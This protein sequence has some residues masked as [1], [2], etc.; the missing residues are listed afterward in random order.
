MRHEFVDKGLGFGFGALVLL[1]ALATPGVAMAAGAPAA[2]PPQPLA[3]GGHGS[4]VA[5]QLIP[6]SGGVVTGTSFAADNAGLLPDKYKASIPSGAFHAPVRIVLLSPTLSPPRNASIVTE[7][8]IAVEQNGMPA[9]VPFA[10]P[11]PLT[12]AGVTT[13]I[14]L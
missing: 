6:T 7:V 11:L 8:G 4:V 2:G 1:A 14:D 9:A 10:K 5:T 12:I 13:Q 3:S